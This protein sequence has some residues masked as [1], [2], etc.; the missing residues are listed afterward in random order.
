MGSAQVVL[1]FDY[2]QGITKDYR[3]TEYVVIGNKI[4][5]GYV[6]QNGLGICYA[7]ILLG[8]ESTQVVLRMD[9]ACKLLYFSE[10]SSF[11]V[12]CNQVF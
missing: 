11:L 1:G 6:I 4:C 2:A 3:H 5:W 9:Y 10:M 8:L 12:L 7:Q